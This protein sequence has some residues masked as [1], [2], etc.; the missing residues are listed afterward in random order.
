MTSQDKDRYIVEGEGVSKTS[1]LNCPF[2]GSVPE[3]E[4]WHG[5]SPKRKMISCV[6]DGC[7]ANPQIVKESERAVIVAWNTRSK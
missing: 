1:I 3:I 2:C 6:F 7:P 5:G 4:S